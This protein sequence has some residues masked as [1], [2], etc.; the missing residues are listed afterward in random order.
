M[1][2]GGTGGGGDGGVREPTTCSDGAVSACESS[3]T[4][5]VVAAVDAVVPTAIEGVESPLVPAG[6]PP[7]ETAGAAVRRA[8]TPRHTSTILSIIVT[9]HTPPRLLS[10]LLPVCYDS[11][12]VDKYLQV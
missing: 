5:A 12:L 11:V 7:A 3:P 10:H 6:K 4:T 9:L 1:Q 2:L 8:C